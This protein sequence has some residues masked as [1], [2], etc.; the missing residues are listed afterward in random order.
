MF[1]FCLF[2]FVC[3][4]VTH[5]HTHT[6]SFSLSHSHFF[7]H[8]HTHTISSPPS[9]LSLEHPHIPGRFRNKVAFI[10]Q[11][12]AA[13]YSFFVLRNEFLT[14]LPHPTSNV[15]QAYMQEHMLVMR[16]LD[17]EDNRRLASRVHN[18]A[19]APSDEHGR[20]GAEVLPFQNGLHC[21][22]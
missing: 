13:Q 19:A 4:P 9:S 1:L 22:A 3:V 14:H 20:Q 7:T 8:T 2:L 11:L 12:K 5:K 18:T 16:R 17:Q 6:L 10:T 21:R 15:K